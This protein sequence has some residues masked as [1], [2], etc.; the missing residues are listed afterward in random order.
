[1]LTR[2]GFKRYWQQIYKH[3]DFQ[4]EL[5][6]V[7][8]EKYVPAIQKMIFEEPME[9]ESGLKNLKWYQ[10][11]IVGIHFV[12]NSRW[13]TMYPWNRCEEIRNFMAVR[14]NAVSREL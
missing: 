13:E 3:E 12:E 5:W 8:N 7:W 14:L 2:T 1:M 10:E 11:N 4:K 9:Y 6:R